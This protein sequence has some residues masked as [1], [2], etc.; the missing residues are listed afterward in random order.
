MLEATRHRHAPC[1]RS[2]TACGGPQ[3]HHTSCASVIFAQEHGWSEE[4]SFV[5]P[6]PVG[7]HSS[8]SM[9]AIAD[10]GQAEVR[11]R[12]AA[13][14]FQRAPLKLHGNGTVFLNF[15]KRQSDHSMTM[16]HGCLVPKHCAGRWTAPT[17]MASGSST[18][19]WPRSGA[20]WPTRRAA[21]WWCTTATSATPGGAL[22]S[23]G[24]CPSGCALP[25]AVLP[26]PGNGCQ[27]TARYCGN[28]AVRLHAHFLCADTG[29]C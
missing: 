13:S 4:A 26:P 10:M 2:C 17:R 1:T 19:A 18:P 3:P 9:L 6:P 21:A 11:N 27:L 20:C 24:L 15:C 29:P 22:P 5:T 28:A 25:A 7:P 8:V 23:C 16:R 12:L 14:C